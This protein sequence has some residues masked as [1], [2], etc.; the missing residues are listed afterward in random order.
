MPAHPASSSSPPTTPITL[1]AVAE[2]NRRVRRFGLAAVTFALAYVALTA[3]VEL[4]LLDGV[5]AALAQLA[6]PDGEWES[7][8]QLLS[9]VPANL[10]PE[11]VGVALVT[12]MLL[13]LVVRRR[14]ALVLLAGLAA[15]TAVTGAG[16]T[17]YLI[18]RPDVQGIVNPLGA[19]P[20]GHATC[21]VVA[22]GLFLLLMWPAPRWWHLALPVIPGSVLGISLVVVG[23]HW[24]TDAAGGALLSLTALAAA[25]CWQAARTG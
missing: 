2:R 17:K 6:R 16:A 3:V 18:A 12:V 7:R 11:R 19:Y 20:S 21:A 10:A 23:M 14:V 13:V 1:P 9:H 15:G 5:D 4:G 25:C 8:Q 24:A 22:A